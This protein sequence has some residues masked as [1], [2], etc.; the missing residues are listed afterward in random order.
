MQII[1]IRNKKWTVGLEWE[2]LPGE[3]SIKD[4]IKEI[5]EKTSSNFGVIVEYEDQHAIGLSKK[6]KPKNPSAN[7]YLALANQEKRSIEQINN[8]YPDWIV[9]EEVGDDKYWLGIIKNGIPTPQSDAILDITTIKDIIIDL[10]V[11]DT[12]TIYSP[13]VEIKALFDSQKKI[14]EIGLNELTSE[15]STKIKFLKLRGIPDYLIKTGM[16]ISVLLI[17]FYGAYTI[18]EGRDLAEKQRI[19]IEK[20]EAEQKA[21]QEKYK[22]ELKNWEK[23][24]LQ[25]EEEAKN[26]I[27]AALRL[28]P[29]G[30][31]STWY[32]IVGDIETGTH[33]WQLGKIECY[34]ENK[35]DKPESVCDILFN[36]T[37]LSTNRMFL[38]DYPDAI[39]KGDQALVKKKVVI[40][41]EYINPNSDNLL[42][43]LYTTKN[44]GFDMISQLQLLKIVNVEHEIK[45][46]SSITYIIPAKPLSPEELRMG[47]KAYTEEQ[48]SIGYAMGDIIINNDNFE[49]IKEI[50]DNV[51][52]K[53]ISVK[54]ATFEP[55]DLGEIK[56]KI[57]LN[58][59]VK[60]DGTGGIAGSDSSKLSNSAIP[61]NEKNE[62]K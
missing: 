39:L 18:M 60:E 44:W 13:C 19:F 37:G 48:K 33:G 49:L 7:L 14:E 24:K 6:V 47:Q 36:R 22:Q 50:I 46:S 41:N 56:W 43:S 2:I 26:K 57:Q 35:T 40:S 1:E 58:Y 62:N 55:K 30:I 12:F 61:T 38:Q 15:I 54:K 10:L 53:G 9:V 28:N 27:K 11:N 29:S 16:A 52:F 5:A 8:Y 23:Q 51:D 17:L 20:Q 4:E 21:Q 59:Y 25:N 31:V 3:S 42:T 34:V 32:K 45:P